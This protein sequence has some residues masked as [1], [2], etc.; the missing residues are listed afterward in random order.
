MYIQKVPKLSESLMIPNIN[1]IITDMMLIYNCLIT[2]KNLTLKYQI[3][4]DKSILVRV[5]QMLE[6]NVV[7]THNC[8]NFLQKSMDMVCCN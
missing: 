6:D 1:S 3:V 7:V 8:L 4:K 2:C 5:M